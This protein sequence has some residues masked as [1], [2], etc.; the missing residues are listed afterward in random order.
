MKKF[1]PFKDLYSDSPN[2]DGHFNELARRMNE[3]VMIINEWMTLMNIMEM[4][5]W[6]DPIT[7]D[8]HIILRA[9]AMLEGNHIADCVKDNISDQTFWNHGDSPIFISRMIKG[10]LLGGPGTMEN[11]LMIMPGDGINLDM[12]NLKPI[13]PEPK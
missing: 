6:N 5:S 11:K 12:L 1:D 10:N 2:I 13:K 8:I 3:Q 7:G 9:S 4:K